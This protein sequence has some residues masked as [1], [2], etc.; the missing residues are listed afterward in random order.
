MAFAMLSPEVNIAENWV[1]SQQQ[2]LDQFEDN[3]RDVSKKVD[4]WAACPFKVVTEQ[5]D[6]ISAEF[7]TAHDLVTKHD[8]QGAVNLTA[9]WSAMLLDLDKAHN[10]LVALDSE[11]QRLLLAA[12]PRVA[13][14]NG[15]TD[16]AASGNV[17]GITDT[18]AQ[19]ET[20]ILDQNFAEAK[21]SLVTLGELLDI[22]ED[23]QALRQSEQRYRDT[24]DL[25]DLDR[26]MANMTSEG[27]P[28]VDV[29]NQAVSDAHDVM[30]KAAETKGWT[31]ATDAAYELSSKLETYDTAVATVD[32][33]K[34]TY[35]KLSPGLM[36]DIS[37]AVP[38]KLQDDPEIKPL[39]EDVATS[40]TEMEANATARRYSA[41]VTFIREARE[42]LGLVEDKKHELLVQINS[43]QVNKFISDEAETVVGIVA[44][45]INDSADRFGDW[46]ERQVLS[47][48]VDRGW[49]KTVTGTLD[50]L[51]VVSGG[52]GNPVA[53]ALFKGASILI[54]IGVENEKRDIENRQDAARLLSLNAKQ[55]VRNAGAE[56][57]KS[58]N[59]DF[60]SVIE[61][62][63]SATWDAIAE[64]LTNR[65]PLEQ[66]AL[67]YLRD[68]GLPNRNRADVSKETFKQ[69]VKMFK[70]AGHIGSDDE[71]VDDAVEKEY[72]T[73]EGEK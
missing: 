23:E 55:Q 57:N 41:A 13:K 43:Q 25:L 65:P 6:A 49:T 56:A 31:E 38:V 27:Y 72:G 66:N 69:L 5:A 44:D 22:F 36:Y 34:E 3:F 12:Q 20:H 7:D 33:D 58:Y 59:S 46:V 15:N 61:S 48:K 40:T 1:R 71:S 37:A 51:T 21:N 67:A 30:L 26:K 28:E 2:L 42:K 63:H 68:A 24:V 32:C 62:K 35:E 4:D 8:Y 16:D 19:A 70:D 53:A 10:E 9:K 73:T 52:A 17:K 54:S 64:A 45:G 29:E 18:F 60:P 14:A 47:S 39:V 11:V 50:F